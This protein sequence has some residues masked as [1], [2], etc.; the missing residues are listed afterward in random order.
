MKCIVPGMNVAKRNENKSQQSLFSQCS[1]CWIR[2]SN[3]SVYE[4]K[5]SYIISRDWK[6]YMRE[7]SESN[8]GERPNISAGERSESVT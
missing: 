5:R 2:C 4:M 3:G 1:D 7:Q 8:S 6:H